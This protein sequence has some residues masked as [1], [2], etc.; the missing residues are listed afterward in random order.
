[1]INQMTFN[2]LSIDISISNMYINSFFFLFFSL[3]ANFHF[4]KSKNYK[5]NHTKIKAHIDTGVIE[6][7]QYNLL[8][9]IARNGSF[10]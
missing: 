1:M 2:S 9:A 5:I 3:H 10:T 8:A 4:R 6:T 7:E